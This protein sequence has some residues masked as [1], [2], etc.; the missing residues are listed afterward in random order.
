MMIRGFVKDLKKH[1]LKYAIAIRLMY[2]DEICSWKWAY[3]LSCICYDYA[4]S[5]DY[6]YYEGEEYDN[7]ERIPTPCGC[8]FFN[9]CSECSS[10][11]VCGECQ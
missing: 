1:G 3:D 9:D 7:E 6:P 2:L 5:L 11:A 4:Y 8:A 10:Y